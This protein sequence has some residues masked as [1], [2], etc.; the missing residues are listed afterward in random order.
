[1]SEHRNAILTGSRKYGIHRRDSDV[2][3]VVFVTE[4]VHDDLWSEWGSDGKILLDGVEFSYDNDLDE[5]H[6]HARVLFVEEDDGHAVVMCSMSED[7]RET[8]GGIE[9]WIRCEDGKGFKSTHRN[10]N[11]NL[12]PVY[13]RERWNI[14]VDG[15][16]A[17]AES[18]HG[19]TREEAIEFFTLLGMPRDFES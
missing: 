13:D 15:T 11:V 5:E 2:D 4:R 8:L 12:I 16:D 10:D 19:T 7:D 14:W 6:E 3:V 18:G 1:M 9:K 17:L